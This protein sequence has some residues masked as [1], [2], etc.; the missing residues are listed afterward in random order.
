MDGE[1]AGEEIGNAKRGDVMLQLLNRHRGLMASLEIWPVGLR[2]FAAKWER[3]K[4]IHRLLDF[5]DLIEIALRDLAVAPGGPAVIVADAGSG[6][7]PVAVATNSK[8]GRAM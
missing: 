4:R 8:V 5:C 2:E 1:E 3:Y 7:E 6:P